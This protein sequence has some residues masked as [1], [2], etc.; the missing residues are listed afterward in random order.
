MVGPRWVTV[1]GIREHPC[2]FDRRVHFFTSVTP[3]FVHE[4]E[5]LVYQAAILLVKACDLPRAVA[6]YWWV[7]PGGVLPWSYLGADVPFCSLI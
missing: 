2:K 6:H 5:R 1:F 4:F 7:N 3:G